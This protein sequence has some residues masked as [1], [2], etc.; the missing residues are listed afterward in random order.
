MASLEVLNPVATTVER[1]VRPAGRL[2]DLAGALG[3]Q[4]RRLECPL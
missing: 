2:A 1:S 4:V 3:V